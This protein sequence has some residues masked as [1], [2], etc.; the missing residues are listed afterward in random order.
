MAD[1]N[2]PPVITGYD[3][4]G[5]ATTAGGEVVTVTGSNLSVITGIA[6]GP[7]PAGFVADSDTQVRFTA[8]AYDPGI[9]S[10][11]ATAK[12][13][14]YINSLTSETDQFPEWTWGGQTRAELQAAQPQPADPAPAHTT[15]DINQPPV[16]ASYDV[17]GSATAAGGEVVT[18]T[19][20][21][22]SVITG[23]AVGPYPAGF[24]ADSDTQVRFT[25]PAYD[26][27]IRS[28]PATAKVAAYINSLTSETDQF[29]EWTWGGQTRAELQAAQPQPA[30]PAPAHT[31]GDINQPPVIASYDVQGSATAAGG[32]VVTVTGSNLSV[33]TGIA[34]GPYPAGFVADSDTQ[35]RF[36]APAYD[37]GIRS[38]P[39]T[40]K[41]AAY[42]NSLTSETDQFP[43]WT[44]GGQTRAELQAAQP[45]PADPAPAQTTGDI[46]RA[47]VITAYDV[48]GSSSTSGGETVT[49]TGSNLSVITGISIGPYPA[50]FV[51]DSD[52][53]VRFTAPAYDPGIRSDPATAKV[54]AYINSLTS[55]SDQFP[56]WT[57]GGQNRAELQAAQG[58]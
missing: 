4:Q 13:A 48:Q 57:W 54:A 43:E 51:I 22:L 1:I 37:P 15:G 19:G 35:V 42:I 12:V 25:A 6:V 23:I 5:S 40:A 56:E 27:G 50:Q 30:D 39:A 17:Q 58:N 24:V 14:A 32:E 29:P 49:V 18:V 2:Q 3:V 47:P 7:Y 36:T 44:W 52:T 55:D 10:D 11:P 34:V 41:V 20:S 53:Q 28:D 46:N 45:Q 26:P 31:T 16:I 9:R 38:D 33:I 21:N 8:P